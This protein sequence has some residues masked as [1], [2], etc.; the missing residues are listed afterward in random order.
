[1]TVLEMKPKKVL[2][3]SAMSPLALY[4]VTSM[5]IILF[6]LSGLGCKISSWP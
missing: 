3:T 5:A 1:M 4:N 6:V 2:H